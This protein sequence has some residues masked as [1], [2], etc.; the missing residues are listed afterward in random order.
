MLMDAEEEKLTPPK[1]IIQKFIKDNGIL[2]NIC[3]ASFLIFEGLT[4]C[5]ETFNEDAGAELMC[6]ELEDVDSN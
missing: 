2:S 6:R 5:L 1:E 4:D 3:A